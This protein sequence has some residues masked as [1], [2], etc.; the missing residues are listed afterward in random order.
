MKLLQ[1]IDE[2]ILEIYV[3]AVIDHVAKYFYRNINPNV[4]H[5]HEH[6]AIC[7]LMVIYV[8]ELC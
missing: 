3:K 6:M 1:P 4:Q 7:L 2:M 5:S 8:Y